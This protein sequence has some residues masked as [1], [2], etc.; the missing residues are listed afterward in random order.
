MS[1]ARARRYSAVSIVLHWTIVAAIVLQLALAA[2]MD[3]RTPAAFARVQLHKSVGV[4]VL[5]LSLVRLAWRLAHRPPAHVAASPWE[6]R[7]AALVH[8]GFYG[9]L[10]GLPLSGWIMVSASSFAIPTVLFGLAPWPDLPGFAALEPGARAAWRADSGQAHAAMGWALYGLLALH[11]GAVL[12]HQLRPGDEVLARMAPGA[13]AGRLW[14][15]RLL[16]AAAGVV[17]IVGA[18][19]LPRPA[20]APSAAPVVQL[21]AAPSAAASPAAAATPAPAVPAPPAVPETRAAAVAWDVR[22]GGRLTFSS[23]WGGD[24]VAGEFTDWRA[25]IVFGE[26]DLAASRIRVTVDLA[27][28]RTGDAQR[29]Q[30]LAG[31]DW[32]GAAETRYAVYEA[33][34]FEVLGGG[35]Y[36]AEGVLTLRGVRLASPLVFHLTM[37]GDEAVVRGEAVLDR[38]AFGVGRNEW[39][40]TALVPAEVKVAFALR[41]RRRP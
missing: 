34:R 13:R 15:P 5:I 2:V 1:E 30:A 28:V 8:A 12:R 4:T 18:V 36:R 3:G 23:A 10:I 40:D 20:A 39:A 17:M 11:V 37:S 41:A 25:D 24:G 26:A 14:E 29:D 35:R 22:P 31:P 33:S 21:D 9:L 16:M 32:L 27:S 6:A 19:L 7:A 38:T